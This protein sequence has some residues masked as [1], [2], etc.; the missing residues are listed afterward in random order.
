MLH[1]I[2]FAESELRF[3]KMILLFWSLVETFNSIA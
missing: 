1:K 2:M 3:I